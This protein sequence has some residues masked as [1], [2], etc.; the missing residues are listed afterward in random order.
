MSEK[1]R[2]PWT[3]ATNDAICRA[4]TDPDARTRITDRDNVPTIQVVSPD[5]AMEQ[6]TDGTTAEI[7]KNGS[8]H[9][10]G[11]ST[12]E[13]IELHELRLSAAQ[14]AEFDA[15]PLNEK[16]QLLAEETEHAVERLWW[17][18][19]KWARLLGV[20]HQA[21]Y[22]QPYWQTLKGAREQAKKQSLE[23]HSE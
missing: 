2:I 21:I 4:F 6:R 5:S 11:V 14:Q 20:T 17:G 7:R 8:T 16:L 15:L 1:Q 10:P 22:K 3:K 18:A 23:R 12:D 19:P 9:D 13:I